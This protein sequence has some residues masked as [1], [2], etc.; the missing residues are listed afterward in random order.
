[1][2]VRFADVDSPDLPNIPAVK[3]LIANYADKLGIDVQV[4]ALPLKLKVQKVQPQ[5]DGLQFTAGAS[6]VTLNSSGV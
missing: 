4:P 1:V 3:A 5:A 2:H 6:N